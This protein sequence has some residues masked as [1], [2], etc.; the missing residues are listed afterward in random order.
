VTLCLERKYDVGA[1]EES[2][3]PLETIKCVLNV[4]IFY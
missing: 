4:R 2:S 1:V 3:T